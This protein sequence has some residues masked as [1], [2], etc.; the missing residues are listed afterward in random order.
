MTASKFS[1][2]FAFLLLV[3]GIGLSAY[4]AISEGKANPMMEKMLIPDKALWSERMALSIM[5]RN[6]DAWMTDFRETPRWAYT[7]GLIMMAMQRTWQH[8]GD[9]RFWEYAKAYADTM[10]DGS[11][12]IKGYD[13]TEFN[14][15]HINAGKMLFLLYDRSGDERYREAIESLRT[16]LRWQPRTNEG[17]YWHK[18]RY[19]RQMW[20]D[21]LYMASPFLAEY[22]QRF[23]E[24]KA[25]DDVVKQFILM[26]KEAKEPKTGL[27]RHGWD[28]SKLQKWSDVR[29]GQS[30]EV[31]GRAMGWY[32]MAL[33]DV[34]DHLPASYSGR[35]ELQQILNRLAATITIYQNPETSL[36]SQVINKREK[37]GNYEEAS[38]ACMFAYALSRGVNQ[39]YLEEKYMDI[40]KKAFQGIL[41]HLVTIDELGI[42]SLTR[43][44]AVAGL[45]GKPYRS[46][47]YDYYISETIRDNDPKGTGPF[48]LASLEFERR[49][50]VFERVNRE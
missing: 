41:D 22:G 45:G 21:G 24:A 8:N 43:C 14:I 27:L 37:K 2:Y 7:N 1:R 32:A 50:M 3:S 4:F 13:V 38:V 36:W 46:G 40:A 11:G 30:P 34:L 48:I 39:G 19:P 29:T 10:I 44:C 16:Q 47:E 49:G 15:D 25:F 5:H 9:E 23:D 12:K 17:G 26:D 28:E 42:M 33:V 20:L 18:L 31:W 35:V 6:P